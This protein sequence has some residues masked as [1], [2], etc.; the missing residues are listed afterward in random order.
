MA[1]AD[2]WLTS[3]ED[4]R[5]EEAR[6]KY[7][8]SMEQ[9][10]EIMREVTGAS[11]QAEPPASPPDAVASVVDIDGYRDLLAMACV[12]GFL[13]DG[14]LNR[15]AKARAEYGITMHQHYVLEGEVLDDLSMKKREA[16]KLARQKTAA[17]KR[18]QVEERAKRAAEERAK[19]EAQEK[20]TRGAEASKLEISQ[21]SI[22]PSVANI[23]S[24][25]SKN[26]FALVD[27]DD[28]EPVWAVSAFDA[29]IVDESQTVGD[30]VDDIDEKKLHATGFNMHTSPKTSRGGSPKTSSKNTKLAEKGK[31][32]MMGSQ[33]QAENEAN[34]LAMRNAEEEATTRK[35]AAEEK[36]ASRK[37]AE[38]EEARIEE[39][40][41]QAKQEAEARAG[42]DEAKQR[43]EEKAKL[44]TEEKAKL[45]V[46]EKAKKA[47]EGAKRKADEKFPLNLSN[48]SISPDDLSL[49]DAERL[50]AHFDADDEAGGAHVPYNGDEIDD[51]L[52]HGTGAD[53]KQAGASEWSA[54]TTDEG[55]QY[56]YNA[57]T[58]E[59]TWEKP[60]GIEIASPPA[61]VELVEEK[62]V[63]QTPI[64]S[65]KTE[66]KKSRAEK[67]SEAKKSRADKKQ[68]AKK[69]KAEKKSAKKG[70]HG[71]AI[72]KH[73]PKKIWKRGTDGK[74][75]QVSL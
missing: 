51:S 3:S 49:A 46:E 19:K 28:G 30:V 27:G 43:A 38:A 67:K 68:E 47:A 21:A 73:E 50:L 45:E 5:L 1:C 7:G 60:A 66:A 6:A 65:K 23:P 39:Q 64:K 11:S 29:N 61:E 2:G 9:H 74:L 36:E 69:T 58:Q 40:A 32:T 22:G 71:G 59:S 41:K 17:G 52:V 33:K 75:V 15:L 55:F 4:T 10:E 34:E 48:T 18:S 44:Q 25:E 57:R 8:V 14:E 16:D 37:A 20:A 42:Q 62:E 54:Y 12:D 26:H 63:E 53:N 72:Q 31:Q 56:Y 70:K 24:P 35:V 13:S